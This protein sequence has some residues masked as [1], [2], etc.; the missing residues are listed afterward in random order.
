LIL[1]LVGPLVLKRRTG[2]F[3]SPGGLILR[4]RAGKISPA[5]D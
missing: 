1:L 5:G 2:L 3:C 4:A